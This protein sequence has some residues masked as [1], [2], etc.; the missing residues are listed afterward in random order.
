MCGDDSMSMC[1]KVGNLSSLLLLEQDAT[2]SLYHSS[3][4]PQLFPNQHFT[5]SYIYFL[6][7]STYSL[8]LKYIV[9]SSYVYLKHS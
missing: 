1:S 5:L 9:L 2:G 8:Y 6:S 7:K 4:G 3:F